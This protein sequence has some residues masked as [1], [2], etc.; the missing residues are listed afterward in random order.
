MLQVLEVVALVQGA[1]R[2]LHPPVPLHMPLN[3]RAVVL[4]AGGELVATLA[5]HLVVGELTLVLRPCAPVDAGPVLV[6]VAELALVARAVRPCLRARAALAVLGPLALVGRAVHVDVDPMPMLHVVA[7]LPL[8]PAP[9]GLDEGA[10]AVRHVVVEQAA[11]AVAARAEQHALAMPLAAE[12]LPP[13]AAA[14]L[15]LHLVP[16]HELVH[17]EAAV[18]H[19]RACD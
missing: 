7:P 6:A 18:A 9:V 10:A 16:L 1:V 8:V 2:P 12:P 19:R 11:V 15:E 14:A 5:M 4:A 17:G 13:I 3:P